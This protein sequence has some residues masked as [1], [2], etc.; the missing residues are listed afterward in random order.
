MQRLRIRSENPLPA[1]FGVPGAR[2]LTIDDDRRGAV[3]VLT[4]DAETAV[5]A[6]GSIPG[7]TFRGEALNLEEIFLAVAGGEE[8][9]RDA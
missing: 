3:A 5:A 4:G 8:P 7:V 9:S 6:L 1:G 2:T